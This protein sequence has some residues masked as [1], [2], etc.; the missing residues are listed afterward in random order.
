MVEELSSA[1][2]HVESLQHSM[3]AGASLDAN[4]K[5]SRVER[6]M[7]G[8]KNRLH[9]LELQN[10]KLKLSNKT[11]V[12]VGPLAAELPQHDSV[13]VSIATMT[14]FLGNDAPEIDL[15][16]RTLRAFLRFWRDLK[17]HQ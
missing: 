17:L 16:G 6:E 14:E 5:N 9:V 2:T 1:H 13:T 11:D 12:E 10:A 15:T 8:L 3:K 7:M 4:L